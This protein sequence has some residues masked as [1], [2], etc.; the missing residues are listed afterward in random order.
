[1][2]AKVTVRPP[3]APQV[4][5]FLRDITDL[6]AL[7]G[8]TVEP[9]GSLHRVK[10]DV[11][12]KAIYIRCQPPT[13]ELDGFGPWSAERFGNLPYTGSP[14]P[15][16]TQCIDLTLDRDEVMECVAEHMLALHQT[17]VTRHDL[18]TAA[19]N[20]E[21]TASRTQDGRTLVDGDSRRRWIVFA[22]TEW[23]ER[24]E[25]C[26]DWEGTEKRTVPHPAALD[27]DDLLLLDQ[28]G[29]PEEVIERFLRVAPHC[30]CAG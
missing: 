6:A 19:A 13:L 27:R 29:T 23:V 3:R 14:I 2:R 20:V 24:I 9:W 17:P 15:T 5:P 26:G 18:L 21:L 7:Y 16:V 1:M 11:G 10:A 22:S 4:D 8:L 25:L 12:S 30:D 28:K